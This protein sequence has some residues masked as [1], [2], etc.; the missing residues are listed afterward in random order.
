VTSHAVASPRVTLS[1]R[2][3]NIHAT[4]RVDPD[5]MTSSLLSPAAVPA[6]APVTASCTPAGWGTFT[7]DQLPELIEFF[8]KQGFAILTGGF[9]AAELTELET[10]L[11]GWQ[12]KVVAGELDARHGTAILDDPEA[13]VQGEPFAHYVCEVSLISEPA[14]AAAHHPP[15]V[16]S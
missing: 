5:V 16:R 2:A 14:R 10:D 3:G 8:R 1:S 6:S 9:S 7:S 15:C 13:R 4:L 11:V 12:N